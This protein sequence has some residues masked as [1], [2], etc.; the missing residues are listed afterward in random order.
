[1]NLKDTLIVGFIALGHDV[2]AHLMFIC[3]INGTNEVRT[4]RVIQL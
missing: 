3:R 2:H 1:M 4:K